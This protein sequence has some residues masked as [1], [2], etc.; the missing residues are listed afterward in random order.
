MDRDNVKG[1]AG[2]VTLVMGLATATFNVFGGIILILL[3]LFI[4]PFTYKKIVEEAANL[5]L[6]SRTKKIIVIAGIIL[7]SVSDIAYARFSNMSLS[8]ES[9][10]KES[11]NEN[12]NLEVH[13][14]AKDE[15]HMREPQLTGDFM[16]K[17]DLSKFKVFTVIITNETDLDEDKERTVEFLAY[18]SIRGH[19]EIDSFKRFNGEERSASKPRTSFS[20]RFVD[21]NG[22]SVAGAEFYTNVF[23]KNPKCTYRILSERKYVYAQDTNLSE[24]VLTYP[25][26]LRKLCK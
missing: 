15:D 4:I 11:N 21:S 16:S 5:E 17:L 23:G 19:I 7:F 13:S 20:H 26:A 8:Q 25:D 22:F 12:I 18:G 3:G 2:A 6:K 10:D 1:L 24:L 14:F 9:T